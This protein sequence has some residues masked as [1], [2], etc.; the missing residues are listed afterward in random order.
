[1][2]F[3]RERCEGDE[4]D[5]PRRERE[6]FGSCVKRRSDEVHWMLSLDKDVCKRGEQRD[7]KHMCTTHCHLI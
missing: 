1:M 4:T 7:M 3:T 6:M 2:E 5:G